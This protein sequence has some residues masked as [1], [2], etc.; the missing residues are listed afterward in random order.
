MAIVADSLR[1]HALDTAQIV[2][3]PPSFWSLMRK[4]AFDEVKLKSTAAVD[5]GEER[6]GMPEIYP[7]LRQGWV[8]QDN[9]WGLLHGT[10]YEPQD[11]QAGV[12]PP[13]TRDPWGTVAFDVSAETSAVAGSEFFAG[14]R[15]QF[16]L[17]DVIRFDETY[18]HG[19]F[20]DLDR[21]LEFFVARNLSTIDPEAQQLGHSL[22][23]LLT[24]QPVDEGYEHPGEQLI[25]DSLSRRPSIAPAWIKR[26]YLEKE[27]SNPVLAG[28]ILKCI[29]QLAS[30]DDPEWAIRLASRG[31][32]SPE[33]QL[34]EAA[35]R[36][37]ESWGDIESSYRLTDYITKETA[38]WLSDYALEVLET[39]RSKL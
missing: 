3:V 16:A 35:L 6:E 31:L 22:I 2:A 20:H 4:E 1:T 32:D 11:Y 19:R 15:Q 10:L 9:D 26:V 34:R 39:M 27:G 13:W 30:L 7:S 25:A 29:S 12:S 23:E 5:S 24:M 37:F 14:A 8:L 28:E 18:A 33:I 17:S 38:L 21:H 36:V